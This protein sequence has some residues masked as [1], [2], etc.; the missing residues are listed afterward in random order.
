MRPTIK[1][2]AKKAGVS[3]STV[4]RVLTGSANVAEDKRKLVLDAIEELGFKRNAVARS[5]R[6]RSTNIIGLIIPDITNPFFPEIAKGVED[7]AHKLGYNVILCNSENS[8]YK[9]AFYLELLRE[10]QVDGIILSGVGEASDQIYAAIDAGIPLVV[11]DRRLEGTEVDT[12][13]TDNVAGGA[14][15]ARR[16]IQAGHRRIG[17]LGGP[18]NIAVSKDRF[19]GYRAAL[20]EAGIDIEE[21]WIRF[22]GFSF[23]AGQRA[24]REFL[25]MPDP[26]TAVVASSDITAIGFIDTLISAGVAVPEHVSVVGFDDITFTAMLRPRLTTIRQPKYLIGET[27]VSLLYDRLQ[28]SDKKAQ[29]VVLGVELVER[30]TVAPPRA[31]SAQGRGSGQAKANGG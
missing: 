11:L 23:E 9:E 21:Q 29:Q 24:A 31:G 1:D 25:E 20:N 10:R 6:T 14:M 15:A 3:P 2:V 22:D 7:A 13:T 27:A 8:A 30:D 17:F 16:L 5:L 28:R 4:S 19:S 18:H 26:P 12:V